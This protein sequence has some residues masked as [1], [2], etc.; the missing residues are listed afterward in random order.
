[1]AEPPVLA[2]EHL[3][4]TYPGRRSNPFARRLPPVV[5]VT[6]VTFQVAA[7]E[8]LALVGES[9]SGKSTI[10]NAVLGLVPVGGGTV[11]I[12][13]ADITRASASQRRHLA[14]TLQVVFQNP[15]GSLNPSLTIG[16]ILSEPLEVTMHL[17]HRESRQCVELLLKSVGMPADSA[18]RYP[19]N[20]SGGQRQRIAIAR[21][22]AVEPKVIVC[23]EPTSSLDVSTQKVVLELL[24]K[25]QKDTGVAYLFIT[26]DLAVVRN[27]ADRVAVL[28]HGALVEV[29]SA[30]QVC[31]S[32]SQ[33]YTRRLV[34]AAPVPSPAIQR[35]R[36]AARLAEVASRGTS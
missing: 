14:S 26:H 15:Y 13:G 21:A 2:V 1:M 27:F 12:N 16:R 33:P 10:G 6:D 32:P 35:Q 20:F 11:S 23:D 34:Q 3:A 36:R 28:D 31:E 19:G 18:D 25:L 7:G 4:I 8:T 30:A 29:G 22:I 9:G 17:D 24:A 5:A